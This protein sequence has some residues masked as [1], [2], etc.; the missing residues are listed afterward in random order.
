MGSTGAPLRNA[1]NAMPKLVQPRETQPIAKPRK[2]SKPRSKPAVKAK[3]DHLRHYANSG[4]GVMAA[5]SAALNGYANAQHAE[6]EWA[7]WG[8]GIV[9][10]RRLDSARN[11]VRFIG[12]GRPS[13][14]NPE[15]RR[16]DRSMA[17]AFSN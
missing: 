1:M 8:M 11:A 17:T 16:W 14:R 13:N 12:A 6:I 15:V 2:V 3:D 4:V 5:L 10:S 7:G 9:A